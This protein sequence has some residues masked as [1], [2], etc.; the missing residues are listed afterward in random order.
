MPLIVAVLYGITSAG[1]LIK[2]DFA[3]FIVWGSYA[4]ANIG[5]IL[6]TRK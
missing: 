6:A 5:L 3:W 2:R 1:F 4:L